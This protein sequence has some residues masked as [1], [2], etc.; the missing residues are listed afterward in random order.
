[1]ETNNVKVMFSGVVF[2]GHTVECESYEIYLS[3]T[4]KGGFL[5]SSVELSFSGAMSVE[6]MDKITIALDKYKNK[7]LTIEAVY[8]ILR[9]IGFK[10]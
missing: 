1:M 6:N 3:N 5:G 9:E 10:E 7:Q 2:S 8:F 4:K